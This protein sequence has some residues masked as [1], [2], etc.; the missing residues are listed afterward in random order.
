MPE[1]DRHAPASEAVRASR[2][3]A[4]KD[5]LECDGAASEDSERRKA[6]LQRYEIEYPVQP[7][8]PGQEVPPNPDLGYVEQAQAAHLAYHPK[9]DTVVLRR[10]ATIESGPQLPSSDSAQQ[11]VKYIREIDERMTILRQQLGETVLRARDA[12]A[13]W[14]DIGGALG[15]TTQAA[16]ARFTEKA[17]ES[18]RLRAAKRRETGGAAESG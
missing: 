12:G 17:R 7:V 11:E 5:Q 13:T 3:S 18:N 6:W 14:A 10:N 16:H 15:I 1:S 8:S 2:A 9:P 4:T